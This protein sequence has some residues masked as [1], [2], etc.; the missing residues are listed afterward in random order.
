MSTTSTR[1]LIS[2]AP[3]GTAPGDAGWVQFGYLE[4]GPARQCLGARSVNARG[5]SA[6]E[7]RTPMRHAVARA[8][9]AR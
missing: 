8:M 6:D 7:L 1:V 4:D 9:H 5:A 3:V 2:V